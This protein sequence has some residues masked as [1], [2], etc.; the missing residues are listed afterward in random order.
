MLYRFS[1]GV[2]FRRLVHFLCRHSNKI[3]DSVF[4]LKIENL[5]ISF[6]DRYIATHKNTHITVEIGKHIKLVKYTND[7][8]N[9]FG[10]TETDCVDIVH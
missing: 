9:L 8:I 1:I 10:W 2:Y 6:V 3:H 7:N 5:N 4:T